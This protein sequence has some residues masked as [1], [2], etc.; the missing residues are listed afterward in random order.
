M[1]KLSP[2]HLL[3]L[4]LLTVPLMGMKC[5]AEASVECPGGK[6]NPKGS[7]KGEWE[8]LRGAS[9]LENL[10]GLNEVL[11]ARQFRIDVS[12]SSVG[13][14]S[15]GFVTLRLVDSTSG[16]VQASRLFPWHKIG[17]QLVLTNPDVV[18]NWALE[19]GDDADSVEYQLEQFSPTTSQGWNTLVTTPVYEGETLATASTTWRVGPTCPGDP[20]QKGKS[21]PG[22]RHCP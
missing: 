16:A 4:M 8:W 21:S 18:N 20:L 14:P 2:R 9:F 6:C 17:T 12:Q 11:D 5:T 15:Q 13:V 19:N 3:P 22:A 10:H 7:V 1:I